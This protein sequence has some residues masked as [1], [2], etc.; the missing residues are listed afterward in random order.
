MAPIVHREFAFI[1][2]L[3]VVVVG[4]DAILMPGSP[5]RGAP[6]AIGDGADVVLD[7]PTL[8]S[9]NGTGEGSGLYCSDSSVEMLGVS[10][11]DN[12]SSGLTADECEISVV[13]LRDRR[14]RS[15]RR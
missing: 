8:A 6:L 3:E 11:R 7:G 1:D 2:N 14:Q 4:P 12:A 9:G 5:N 15:A 13:G 10:L